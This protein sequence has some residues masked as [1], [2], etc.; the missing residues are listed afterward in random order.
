M[1][2]S[3]TRQSVVSIATPCLIVGVYED[4][5]G[6]GAAADVNKASGGLLE[7]LRAAGDIGAKLGQSR[8]LYDVKG[9]KAKRVMIV[10]CGPSKAFNAD[11]FVQIAKSAAS[12]LKAMPVETA[13][14]AL[15]DLS[16]PDREHAW[17]LEQAVVTAGY[18]CYQYTATR[19]KKNQP[20]TQIKSM[21]VVGPQGAGRIV[22][23]AA[24]IADG[25]DQARELGNLPPNICTPKYLR[26]LARKLGRKYDKVSTSVMDKKAM[27][28]AGFGSLLAVARGSKNPPYLIMMHYKG[29]KAS[30]APVALV[31]K[32]ITFDTGGISLKPGAG[33][34]EMKFDMCGAASVFGAVVAC[35]EMN[36]PLNVV[37]VVPAVENMPGGDAYRPGDILTSLSGQT[38]EVLNTDAE[39]RLILCDALTHV[40]KFKPRS[41]VD[42]ATLTGACVIAL[43]HHASGLMSND[44]ELT[45]ELLDA[46]QTTRDRAW[47]LPMWDEY[48][49]QISSIYAD[50]ANIGGRSAG[51]ITA[52][53]FLSRFTK[54]QRWAHLDIAGAAWENARKEGATGRPVQLLTQY[55]MDQAGR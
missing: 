31:G 4:A 27:E 10:S 45:Q 39:G 15:G 38:I 30:S 6:T 7:R 1:K 50:M 36:L 40:Q 55:L 20:K 37:G 33:M 46:G 12:Q 14:T 2:F 19:S 26:D 48:Q 25:V 5:V 9:V 13:V 49:K 16:V 34:E 22:K 32:G 28:K 43:G 18:G 3:A 17:C 53:C 47:E 29:A 8:T 24:A 42:I 11:R 41:I 51:T 21:K 44:A 23:R 54:G 52:A 35:A